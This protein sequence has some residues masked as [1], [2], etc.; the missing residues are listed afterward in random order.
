MQNQNDSLRTRITELEQENTQLKE[1]DEFYWQQSIDFL[2]N[3]DFTGSIAKLEE[4]KDR[5]PTSEKVK[6]VN[7]KIKEIQR[8]Q[9]SLFD[10]LIRKIQKM[11]F[12]D[13]I[14]EIQSFLK[15][16]VDP[17]YIKQANTKLEKVRNQY[18]LVR[19]EKEAEQT[20]GVSLTILKTGWEASGLFR[21]EI[22]APVVRMKVENVSDTLIDK[23]EIHIDFIKSG[24]KEIFGDCDKYVVGYTDFPLKPGFS[25]TAICSSGTGYTNYINP[26][27]M[28]AEIYVNDVFFKSIYVRRGM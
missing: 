18:E 15:K 24:T 23:I 25:K 13:D 2:Q 5:F 4:L 19:E 11:E 10:E 1:T 9:K 7:S 22:F 26:P 8:I 20:T 21:S 14:N 12:V 3:D 28:T 17:I 16:K 6:N 27:S